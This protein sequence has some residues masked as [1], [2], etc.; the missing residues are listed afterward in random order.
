MG[1]FVRRSRMTTVGPGQKVRKDRVVFNSFCIKKPD[2]IYN[3]IPSARV[4]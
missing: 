4:C 2:I 1:S 3:A